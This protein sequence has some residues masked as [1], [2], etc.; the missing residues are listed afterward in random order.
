L[1]TIDLRSDTVTHPTDEMRFE[2]SRAEVGDDVYGE[3][4][5]VN[6]LEAMSARMM[7]KEAALFTPSGTMSN[8]VG[9]LAQTQRGD[10]VIVGSEA[11]IFWYEVGGMSALGGVMP[12]TVPNSPDGTMDLADIEAAIRSKNIHYPPTTLLTLENTHNRR[13]GAVLSAAYIAEATGLAHRHGLRV[14][15]DGARI[16]NASVAL[17]VPAADLVCGADSVSFCVS[18]GLSAPVGSLLCGDRA[19]VERSRKYRKMLGGGMRQAG[20]LAA[21]GIVALEK[22]IDR[23]AEDHANAS[24]L[25]QGLSTIHGIEVAGRCQT[26]IVMF[27]VAPGVPGQEFVLDMESR[28]VRLSPRG[29]QAFR[30]VTH[31]MIGAGDVQEALDRISAYLRERI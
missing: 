3:D 1:K 17:G 27:E 29:G 5:T 19:F 9:T 28:G 10:E 20:I 26:N 22:M 11:H 23:L 13:G 24:H 8:L 31:R 12:R 7:G 16:F 14:H 18:K 15:L 30:A 25:A 21:A 6:R 4:P 2:M